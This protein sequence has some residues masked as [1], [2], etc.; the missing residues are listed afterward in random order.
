MNAEQQSLLVA[1][2]TVIVEGKF[3][4]TA[5][6]D[7]EDWLESEAVV[8]PSEFLAE[9][10]KTALGADILT[11]AQRLP[12]TTPKW[13]YPME[14]DNVAAIPLAS[15][16]NDWWEK[17]LP[18]VARKNARR[19]AKRGVVTRSVDLTDDVVKGI[20][21]INDESPIVQGRRSRHYG[22]DFATVKRNYSSF[23]DR[24][25]FIAAYCGEDFVG[26]VWMIRMGPVMGLTQLCTKHEHYDKRPA[27]ALIA[28]AV[29]FC[30]ERGYAYLTYGKYLYGK[31]TESSLMEFK[32]RIGFEQIPVPRY[33]VPLTPKGR[34]AIRMNVHLGF[35]SL[36][37]RRLILSLVKLR[38]LYY[39]IALDRSR[40]KESAPCF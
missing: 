10:S 11:F 16:F 21:E 30:C 3:L 18:Q 6:V 2:R 25:D 14:W 20:M 31:N 39:K 33:Y 34:L 1:N 38:S 27:N 23:P 40:N 22:K 24:S 28:R 13:R 36:L 29:E 37:P 15:G 32:R 26:F 7:S 5:S 17:R 12:E 35:K 8:N 9:L 4:R 19:A